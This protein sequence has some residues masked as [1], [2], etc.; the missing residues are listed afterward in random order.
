MELLPNGSVEGLDEAEQVDRQVATRSHGR[1]RAAMEAREVDEVCP[2]S[3]RAACAFR[4]AR[5]GAA[6]RESFKSVK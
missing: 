5:A 1:G 4:M 2:D 6:T 3:E